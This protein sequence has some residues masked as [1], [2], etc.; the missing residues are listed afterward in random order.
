MTV[1]S[2]ALRRIL[3]SRRTWAIA[4]LPLLAVIIGALSLNRVT[5]TRGGYAAYV[6][7]LLI[8]LIV[9]LVGFVVAASAVTDERDDLTIL[10]VAQTPLPRW[11]AVTEIWLGS[12]AASLLL[13][14]APV[15]MGVILAVNAGQDATAAIDLVVACVLGTAAYTALAVL[16]ALWTRRAAIVGLVYVLL[17]ESIVSGFAAGTRNLSIAQ[18]ARAIAA[19]SV[20]G[21]T[22]YE[23]SPPTIGAGAAIVV[24]VAGTVAVLILAARRFRRMNLP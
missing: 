1:A 11:R 15:G 21:R 8:P 16:T 14:A 19:R 2:I 4:S 17:L 18:H 23:L 13:A 3:R 12:W 6:T 22:Q 20:D 24:L 9:G 5:D 7:G 10:Y